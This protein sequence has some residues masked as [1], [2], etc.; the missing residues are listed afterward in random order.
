[1]TSRGLIGIPDT[2]FSTAQFT[3]GNQIKKQIP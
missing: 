2:Y 3:T 1:M